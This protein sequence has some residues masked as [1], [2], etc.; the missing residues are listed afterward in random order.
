MKYRILE[1]IVDGKTKFYPQRKNFLFWKTIKTHYQ[2]LFY[3]DGG[4]VTKYTAEVWIE[5]HKKSQAKTI[6][7][8][9]LKEDKKS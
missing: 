8:N 9:Y 5:N 6:I 7:H 1:E 2:I 4:L 3:C